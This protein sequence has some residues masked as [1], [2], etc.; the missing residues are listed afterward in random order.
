[1]LTVNVTSVRCNM[2]G[3]WSQFAGTIN[4]QNTKTGSYAPQLQ[5]NNGYGL[6]HATVQGEFHNNGTDVTIGTLSDKV[7]VTGSGITTV[8]HIDAK[9]NKS[10][11]GVISSYIEVEG[12]L[13]VSDDITVT[14][15]GSALKAGE[16]ITLW[17]AGSFQVNSNVT[18]TLPELPDGL[19]WDTS[20]LMTNEGRLKVTNVPTAIDNVQWSMVNGQ[21]SMFNGQWFT[22]DGRRLQGKP[23]QKGI[24]IRNGKKVIVK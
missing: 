17:K 11:S 24:Y 7:S 1:M 21:C 20:G 18:I 6:G 8:K 16:I 12:V 5:W 2:Q 9:I 10:R 23:T 19:Y 14:H 22:L 3:D 15:K 13:I 4:F